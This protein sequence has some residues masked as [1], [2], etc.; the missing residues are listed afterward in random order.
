M[1]LTLKAKLARTSW[2]MGFTFP[3]V[4]FFLRDDLALLEGR[5][6]TSW[7]TY[8]VC[9]VEQ[10]WC[11]SWNFMVRLEWRAWCILFDPLFFGPRPW[12]F[13]SPYRHVSSL[14]VM[15]VL[16]F[17]IVFTYFICWIFGLSVTL[18]HMLWLS[19]I[20]FN[21]LFPYCR[22]IFIPLTVLLTYSWPL[23]YPTLWR[24]CA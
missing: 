1:A 4:S 19:G 6:V 17:H 2:V 21:F 22:D 10:L 9:L 20:P 11:I 24:L 12:L 18:D 8:V 15:T 13:S 16:S 14:S 7:E 3:G 5:L 23:A